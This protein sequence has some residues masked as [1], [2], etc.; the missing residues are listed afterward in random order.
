LQYLASR[1]SD[2]AAWAITDEEGMSLQQTIW[3]FVYGSRVPHI[4]TVQGPVFA[5]VGILILLQAGINILISSSRPINV[6]VNGAADLLPPPCLSLMLSL[7]TM[8]LILTT[9]VKN[10]RSQL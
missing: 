10:L 3:N 7:M 1:D 6:F 2:N 5:L 4:I 8:T 9:A